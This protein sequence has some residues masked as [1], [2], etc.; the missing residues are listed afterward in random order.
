MLFTCIIELTGRALGINKKSNYWVYNIYLI[1]EAGFVTI[2]Y[3]HFLIKYSKQVN[4]I[5]VGT[6]ILTILY[7]YE[8]ASHGFF[9]YNDKTETVMLVA[10]LTYYAYIITTCL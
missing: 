6:S 3:R 5:G 7:I 4:F 1:A 10:I 2:M 8:I 9:I